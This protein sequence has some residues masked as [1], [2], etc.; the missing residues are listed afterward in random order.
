[1][2]KNTGINAKQCKKLK[3]YCFFAIYSFLQFFKLF[4][5]FWIVIFFCKTVK[6]INLWFLCLF[7]NASKFMPFLYC[8]AINLCRARKDFTRVNLPQKIEKSCK[9]IN[10]RK[11]TLFSKVISSNINISIVVVPTTTLQQYL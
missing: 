7:C 2:Q 3:I 4:E 1:M 10:W 5:K 6:S 9:L 8:S 11:S